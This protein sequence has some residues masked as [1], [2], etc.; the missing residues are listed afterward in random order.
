MAT[1]AEEQPI[2]TGSRPRADLDL[3]PSTGGRRRVPEIAL[4]LLVI[5]VCA[6]AA[7][8]WQS[9]S[10]QREPALALRNPIERGDVLSLGDLQ[11]IGISSDADLSSLPESEAALVVG[12]IARSDLPAGVL[13]VPEQFSAGSLLAPGHAVVG[14]LLEA[15]QFP[16]RSLAPGDFVAVILT[17]PVGSSQSF[18]ATSEPVTLVDGA[19]VVEAVEIGVQGRHLISLELTEDEAAHVAVAASANRVRLIRVARSES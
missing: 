12:R 2:A 13:V 3:A 5:V 15:G 10:T 14:L 18:D 19:S 16:T 6:S 9:S 11:V 17:L 8:W 7:L 4:G 1:R